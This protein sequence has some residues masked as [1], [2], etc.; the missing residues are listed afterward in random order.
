MALG[1]VPN[2]EGPPNYAQLNG[3][4]RNLERLQVFTGVIHEQAMVTGFTIGHSFPFHCFDTLCCTLLTLP[5][6]ES[7]SFSHMYRRDGQ[8]ME[9]GQSL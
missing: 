4:A 1:I 6:L 5:A 7:V 8:D 2:P 3:R 9:D